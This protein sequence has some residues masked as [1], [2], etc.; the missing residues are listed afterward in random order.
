MFNKLGP[1]DSTLSRNTKN[2]QT[3]QAAEVQN[4]NGKCNESK[5]C[6]ECIMSEVNL[7][8]PSS[9]MS[10]VLD[11]ELIRRQGICSA[12]VFFD[13]SARALHPDDYA[14]SRCPFQRTLKISWARRRWFTQLSFALI[15][16]F[17]IYGVASNPPRRSRQSSSEADAYQPAELLGWVVLP[18][19]LQQAF[20]R[21][22]C[23]GVI[24]QQFWGSSWPLEFEIGASYIALAVSGAT[25][26][27]LE[28]DKDNLRICTGTLL[29]LLGVLLSLSIIPQILQY[30]WYACAQQRAICEEVALMRSILFVVAAVM[31]FVY[32]IHSF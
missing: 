16:P 23:W 6:D 27:S 13:S 30:W 31:S 10:D 14:S 9:G 7:G 3:H 1:P 17:L 22:I 28:L 21:I 4:Q 32:A 12:Q 24:P 25:L 19:T 29:L 8:S 15:L 20:R 2:E 18:F 11:V 5:V 26:L